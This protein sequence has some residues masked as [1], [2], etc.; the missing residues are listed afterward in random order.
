MTSRCP[1]LALALLTL[2]A[3]P[4]SATWSIILVDTATG[5]V[6]VGAATCLESLDLL[7][8]LPV[9][10]VG[11]GGG[12]AQ[13]AIDSTAKNRKEIFEN[14]MLGTPPDQIIEILLDGD[15]LWKSRQYGIADSSPAAAGFTGEFANDYKED[16]HGTVGT[17]TYAIQGNV[18]TGAPVISAAVAA[19][20]GTQGSLS[21]KLLAGMEAARSMGGDGRCSCAP[22]DPTGCGSP[23]PSFTKS[24]HIGFMVVARM[25][26]TDG[27]CTA[28]VGCA[29]GNYWLS[30]NV[31]NQVE[32]DPDPVLQ[33]TDLYAD[34]LDT[35]HGHPDGLRS[36]AR[37]D[38]DVLLADGVSTRTLSLG[39]CDYFG[40][41]I[42]AGGAIVTVAH[43]PG[44]AGL[45]VLGP[46][47]D[48]GD[49]TYSIE[50]TAGTGSGTD[51]FEVRVDDGF[52][53]AMLYPYPALELRPALV[54]DAAALSSTSGGV[55][56]LDLLGPSADH[57]RL[58]LLAI[59]G[60][61]SVPGLMMP[62][63]LVVPLNPDRLFYATSSYAQAGTLTG[64]RGLLDSASQAEAALVLQPGDLAFMAGLPLTLAWVTMR[65]VDFA[66][67]AVTVDILP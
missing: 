24:A 29:N 16:V 3:P 32:A 13:S 18:L 25:G 52:K 12:A 40:D 34:F 64:S 56:Q 36:S 37:F 49:G 31:K 50:V 47:T 26:D 30:L 44:S 45:S 5:E 61:G 6:G 1:A 4:V 35:L 11:K 67:N 57:D 21:D 41:P 62:G 9:V 33:L 27:V 43:A 58:Y 23:P 48:Q 2:L 15:I 8:L 60:S 46:V 55:A 20:T 14:L 7:K 66:S 65:P 19:V 63:G 59:S 51:L 53:P 28:S 42:L 22:G 17:L 39:F 54:A 10:V 38:H